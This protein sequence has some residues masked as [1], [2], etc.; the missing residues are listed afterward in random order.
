MKYNQY[1]CH[2]NQCASDTGCNCAHYS[3]DAV[4]L[5]ILNHGSER[6][7]LYFGDIGDVHHQM[8]TLMILSDLQGVNIG[9]YQRGRRLGVR[10][11]QD[12]EEIGTFGEVDCL[13]VQVRDSTPLQNMNDDLYLISVSGC[14]L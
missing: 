12:Q 1:D 7:V 8:R 2:Q 5:L 10:L 3:H 4:I 14:S 9:D 6:S 11:L 13:Q